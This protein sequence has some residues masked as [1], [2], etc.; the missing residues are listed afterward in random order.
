LARKGFASAL[1]QTFAL[2]FNAVAGTHYDFRTYWYDGASAPRM[3]L[4]SVVLRPGPVP[5]FTGAQALNGAAVFNVTGVPGQTYSLL[6]T[7]NL[8]AA[9]WVK[10]GSV[11]IPANLGFAQA[12]DTPPAGG[13]YYR[14]SLP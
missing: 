4:R 12:T 1:Y 6:G 9:Q 13:R 11:S 8:A 7:T 14:L 5:F 2:N 3:T 10:V